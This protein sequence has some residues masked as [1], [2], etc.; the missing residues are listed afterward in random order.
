[1]GDH[2]IATVGRRGLPLR[3]DARGRPIVALPAG[4]P[5]ANSGGWQY[6]YRYVIAVDLGRPLRS[7]EHAHH[8]E[9]LGSS[10]GCELMLAEYH[11]ALHASHACLARRD[12]DTGRFVE[13][14]KPGPTHRVARWKWLIGRTAEAAGVAGKTP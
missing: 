12:P 10:L 3:W 14:D 7:D 11:N 6:A 1:M 4:D 8:P 2:W 13:L 9:G 5:Y